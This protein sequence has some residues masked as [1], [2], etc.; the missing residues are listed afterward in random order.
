M[1]DA[2]PTIEPLDAPFGAVARGVDL[3]RGIDPEHLRVLVDALHAHRVL[4]IPGQALTEDQYFAFGAQW[5]RPY[6]H[7]MDHLRMPGYPAMMAIGNTLDKDRDPGVR[8]GAAY[9]HT[10]QAYEVEPCSATMLYAVEVPE[11]GG[12]T[13]VADLVAAWEALS[14][15]E[16]AELEGLRAIHVYG[17][18]AGRDGEQHAVPLTDPGQAARVPAVTQPIV[19]AHPATGRKSLFAVAG[20]AVGIEGMPAAEGGALLRRL[21]A[22]ATQDRFVLR[23]RYAVGDVAIWDN[24]QTL[25]SAV[26]IDFAES[27]PQRRLLW[28]ISVKGLPPICT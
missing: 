25:H 17:G 14:P 24:A 1:A 22:H 26:P 23:Y 9:W 15:A 2:R 21:K 6:P 20:T 11:R 27:A 10:D 18:A 12:E 3:S 28:R 19:R 13:M 8:N 4:I 5:G 7:F 16:Q